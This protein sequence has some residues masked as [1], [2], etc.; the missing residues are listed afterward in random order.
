MSLET[1]LWISRGRGVTLIKVLMHCTSQGVFVFDIRSWIST[2]VIRPFCE[3]QEA[4]VRL[5]LRV[6]VF[7]IVSHKK[8]MFFF[9]IFPSTLSAH[10]IA[11]RQGPCMEGSRHTLDI[12]MS[13]KRGFHQV[14]INYFSSVTAKRQWRRPLKKRGHRALNII[15]I[16]KK[17]LRHVFINSFS[18]CNY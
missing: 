13:F 12:T 15:E 2:W 11:K 17:G 16:F 1:L 10:V 18:L 6:F 4:V 9:F 7:F 14:F 8:S 3:H 5:S